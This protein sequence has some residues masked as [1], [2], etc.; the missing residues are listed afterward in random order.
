[1]VLLFKSNAVVKINATQVDG[2]VAVIV[3]F[4]ELQVVVIGGVRRRWIGR[5]EVQLADRNGGLVDQ[6]VGGIEGA[7]R[8]AAAA[9]SR[10]DRRARR[11]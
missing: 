10:N 8:C 5:I 1:M 11:G 2:R 6:E 7:P 9:A 4:D 3:D